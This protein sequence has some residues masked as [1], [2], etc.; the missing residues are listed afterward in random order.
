M[1]AAID[2]Q[3][4]TGYIVRL[5]Q[6][7]DGAGHVLRAAPTFE[8]RARCQGGD[9]AVAKVWR[10]QHGAWRYGVD[11][12]GGGQFHRQ[13]LRQR[14]QA[15]LADTVGGEV[16]PRVP[17]RQIDDVD[18]GAPTA[19][20]HEG[21]QGVADKKRPVNRYARDLPPGV[22]VVGWHGDPAKMAGAIDHDVNTAKALDDLVRHGLHCGQVGH[23]ALHRQPLDPKRLDFGQCPLGRPCR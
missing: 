10:R 6:V 8:Q 7:A 14:Q 1:L 12:N 16:G 3:R 9:L 2:V 4:C 20:Q 17:R 5:N 19:R 13:L 23:V 11:A 21:G 18:D 22:Q 15:G